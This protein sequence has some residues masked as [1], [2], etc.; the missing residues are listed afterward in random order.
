MKAVHLGILLG[1][2]ITK[3]GKLPH[4]TLRRIKKT[5]FLLKQEKL[6]KII[7]TG[8]YTSKNHPKLSEA[9]LM[10][11]NLLAQGIKRTQL[12]LDEQAKDTLG[13]AIFS[14]KLC[15]THNLPKK[16]T[17]ITSNYHMSRAL[18]I[19]QHIFGKSYTFH[20]VKSKPFILHK[21]Q[22]SL[23]ELESDGL[24]QLFLSQVKVGDHRKAEKLLFKFL[25]FYK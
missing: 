3:E 18:R 6:N 19:F 15:L 20:A 4:D 7:L 17:L 13:N 12:I 5:H 8:G 10:Q 16:I 1:G 24:D 23:Q 25:P 22:N 9:K 14:K 2:G 11:T 21:I